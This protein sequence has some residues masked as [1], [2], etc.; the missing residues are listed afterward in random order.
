[1]SKNKRHPLYNGSE[2]GQSNY[3]VYQSYGMRAFNSAAYGQGFSDMAQT[4][5]CAEVRCVRTVTHSSGSVTFACKEVSMVPLKTTPCDQSSS[6][7]LARL[8]A[9]NGQLRNALSKQDKDIELLREQNETLQCQVNIERHLI[10]FKMEQSHGQIEDIARDFRRLNEMYSGVQKELAQINGL[11]KLTEVLP[12]VKDLAEVCRTL[13]LTGIP[14]DICISDRL[15]EI[16]E[17]RFGANKI[18]P[19]S[20]SAFD[21]RIHERKDTSRN[22]CIVNAC[23]ACGWA[24]DGQVVLRAIVE[25][26]DQWEDEGYGK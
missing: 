26:G 7:K 5:I 19:A 24:L 15:S 3:D 16:L 20:G 25:T 4:D 23:L 2:R 14:F 10:N 6:E 21:S 17:K 18:T 13:Q 22:G 8:E 1:M 12:A 9:E 11:L